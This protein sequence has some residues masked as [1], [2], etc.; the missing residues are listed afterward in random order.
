MN[1]LLLGA[2]IGCVPF[3]VWYAL[4]RFRASP[5]MLIFAP[6]AMAAGALWAVAPDLPRLLGQHALYHRWARDPRTDI[7][8]WHYTI[9]RLESDSSLYHAGLTLLG[10]ALLT[11]AWR[12]L[13]RAEEEE[14]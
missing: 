9:D 12:E 2:A 8:F 5:A 6:L 13:R 11:I 10:A 3:A 14:S 4:R 1:Q 7:F